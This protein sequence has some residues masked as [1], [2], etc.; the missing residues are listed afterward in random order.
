MNI[1]VVLASLSLASSATAAS[2]PIKL[3]FGNHKPVSYSVTQCSKYL[4]LKFTFC[5]EGKT[6]LVVQIDNDLA[7]GHE[8]DVFV[9][10]SGDMEETIC[11]PGTS[12]M[13]THTTIR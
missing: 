1:F 3:N 4:P 11:M 7:G 9:V 8:N 2:L 12:V 10:V 6:C 5:I 13:T